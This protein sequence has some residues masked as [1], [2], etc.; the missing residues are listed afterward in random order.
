MTGSIAPAQIF[1]CIIHIEA[2][3]TTLPSD[4]RIERVVRIRHANRSIDFLMREA[5]NVRDRRVATDE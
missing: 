3:V 1:I 4:A 2:S 5:E